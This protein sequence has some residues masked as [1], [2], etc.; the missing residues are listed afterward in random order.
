MKKIISV[1]LCI[2]ALF[3]M[4]GCKKTESYVQPVTFY[5]FHNDFSY[6]AHASAIQGEIRE[7]AEMDSLE[8]TLTLYLQG[9]E[10]EALSSP[11]PTGMVL[12][13]AVQEADTLL[14]TFTRQLGNL[15]GLDLT[16]ACCCIARTCL[17]LTDAVNITIQA[18]DALIGG[19]RSLT[20]HADN[21]LLLDQV[22]EPKS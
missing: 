4:T 7:G 14:L 21:I 18:Q 1:F 13:S 10:S 15:S 6:D 5:Y 16:I 9:P 17:E 19:E 8:Q 11:F 20:F 2:L 22:Q 3:C 12:I